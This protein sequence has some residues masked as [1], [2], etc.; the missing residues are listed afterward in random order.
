MTMENLRMDSGKLRIENGIYRT[1]HGI[2]RK[3]MITKLLEVVRGTE[4]PIIFEF[5]DVL[6]EIRPGDSMENVITRLECNRGEDMLLDLHGDIRLESITLELYRLKAQGW[7]RVLLNAGN[8]KMVEPRLTDTP[9]YLLGR[10][11]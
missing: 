6:V 9:E 2:T 4:L 5:N 3:E 11:Q 7:S 1:E 10:L 8:G